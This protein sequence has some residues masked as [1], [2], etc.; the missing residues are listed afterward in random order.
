MS[1]NTRTRILLTAVAALLLVTMAVGG[2]LAWLTDVTPPVTNTFSPSDIHIK[3]EESNTPWS[4]Q[5]IPGVEKAKDPK[6]TVDTDKTN[7]PIFVYV[8]VEMPASLKNV[9]TVEINTTDW[10]LVAGTE[11]TDTTADTYT[12]VYSREWNPGDPSAWYVLKGTTT[13]ANGAVAVDK[14]LTADDLYNIKGDMVFTAY[15]IQQEGFNVETG[16]NEVSAMAEA[17]DGNLDKA[18]HEDEH[19][20]DGI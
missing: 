11:V 5:L 1:K 17:N 9:L 2:T 3:L 8:K 15:A 6:V 10:T 4:M 19:G 13:N 16:W 12:A 18:P 7:V 14:K 20:T